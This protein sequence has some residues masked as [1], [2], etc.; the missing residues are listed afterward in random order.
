MGVYRRELE[1]RPWAWEIKEM[2]WNKVTMHWQPIS[3]VPGLSVISNCEGMIVI[4][5][6]KADLPIETVQ[7]LEGNFYA[8]SELKWLCQ[9]PFLTPSNFRE[10]CFTL[11]VQDK[12][13]EDAR[14]NKAVNKSEKPHSLGEYIVRILFCSINDVFIQYLTHEFLNAESPLERQSAR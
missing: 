10:T 4:F 12:K 9:H 14:T 1:K 7:M 11:P 3:N 2:T 13:V 5:C 6:K 8:H